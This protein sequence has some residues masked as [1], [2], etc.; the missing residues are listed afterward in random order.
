MCRPNTNKALGNFS[1]RPTL[2]NASG[3]WTNGL[4]AVTKWGAERAHRP[5]RQSGGAAK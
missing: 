3:Y 2:N 1:V 4:T 5:G